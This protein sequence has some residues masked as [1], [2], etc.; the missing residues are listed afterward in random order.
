MH[1]NLIAGKEQNEIAPRVNNTPS[2]S[3]EI[4]NLGCDSRGFEDPLQKTESIS[5]A[6]SFSRPQT[7]EQVIAIPT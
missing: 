5:A 6:P 3:Q 4:K 7:K 2:T 1:W